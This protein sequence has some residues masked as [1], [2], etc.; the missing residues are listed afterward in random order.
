MEQPWSHLP[1]SLP[2]G[3]LLL[4]PK[5]E[6]EGL[7]LLLASIASLCEVGS[8]SPIHLFLNHR[9]AQ[10]Q[11]SSIPQDTR[12]LPLLELTHQL[13]RSSAWELFPQLRGS[14][15]IPTEED[16]GL[17]TDLCLAWARPGPALPPW[18]GDTYLLL[19][20]SS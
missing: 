13:Q 15:C 20:F 5:S 8:A 18:S 16:L 3:V 9:S 1:L 14:A 7:A 12:S 10:G 4:G 2:W 17:T 19:S 6:E 11:C